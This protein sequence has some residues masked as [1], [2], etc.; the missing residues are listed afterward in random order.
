M[1]KKPPKKSDLEKN[2]LQKRHGKT[3]NILPEYHLIVTEGKKTEP[4]YFKGLKLEIDLKYG[5]RG[6]GRIDIRIEGEG[7]NTLT[8]LDRAK[9]HVADS[10]NQIRHVWLVY[11][12]DDFPLDN[13]DNT[14]LGCRDLSNENI[15]YHAL[16]SNQCIELW[17]MLHFDYLQSDLHRTEYK[18]RLDSYLNVINK[19]VYAKNR[20]Y[21]YEVLREFMPTA[22]A[23]A[24]RL[25]ESFIDKT[26]SRVAPG[27][28]IYELFEELQPYMKKF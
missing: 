26:P 16:W 15:T 19:G 22:I 6:R 11:D 7:V 1:S 17:F 5:N 12:K 25:Y 23:N 8:L 3:V 20:S 13:F 14:A 10:P 24:K 18:P 21:I 27:T 2:W 9:N 28:M 4:L